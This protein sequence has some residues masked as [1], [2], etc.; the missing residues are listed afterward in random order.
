MLNEPTLIVRRPA[1]PVAADFP[2]D[3][4]PVLARL[5]AARHLDSVGQLQNTL[6]RLE[7]PARLKGMET[8]IPLLVSM[9]EQGKHILIVAD[10]DA[11]GIAVE[12]RRDPALDGL[13][14]KR[15]TAVSQYVVA[16]YAVYPP[17]TGR[18]ARRHRQDREQDQTDVRLRWALSPE[19]RT[20]RVQHHLR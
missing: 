5:Y 13:V 4:H 8:A 7:S 16:Q 20:S 3:L 11:D 9:L 1:A 2:A 12:A 19:L 14:G 6:D 10:F 17:I 15:A 18:P